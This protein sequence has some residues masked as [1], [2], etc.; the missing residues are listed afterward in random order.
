[1][2]LASMH[3]NERPENG[4]TSGKIAIEKSLQL[5][6]A[7]AATADATSTAAAMA[8]AMGMSLHHLACL[9]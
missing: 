6:V 2:I 9:K 8:T 1:M 4:S 3:Y 7:I 5:P